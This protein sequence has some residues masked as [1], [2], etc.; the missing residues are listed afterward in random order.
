MRYPHINLSRRHRKSPTSTTS[1]NRAKQ[2][3][4]TG[5]PDRAQ[6]RIYVAAWLEDR[7]FYLLPS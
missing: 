4:T 7:L 5:R 1:N 2:I 3:F 6:H